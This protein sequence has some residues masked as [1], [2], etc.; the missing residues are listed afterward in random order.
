MSE[1]GGSTCDQERAILFWV[2]QSFLT[3][4]TRAGPEGAAEECRD[5]GQPRTQ[6][7][8]PRIHWYKYVK[9]LACVRVSPAKCGRATVNPDET[10]TL[11]I[12]ATYLSSQSETS[13]LN[14]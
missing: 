11:V 2:A 9:N 4:P 10:A 7:Q 3:T 6:Q 14:P 13:K 8:E 5:V 12:P 1:G